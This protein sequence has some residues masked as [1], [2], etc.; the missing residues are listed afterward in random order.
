[1]STAIGLTACVASSQGYSAGR[2]HQSSHGEEPDDRRDHLG[3]GKGTMEASVV[4]PRHARFL[5]K[6]LSNARCR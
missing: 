6:N 5:A 2:N 3:M 1:V 4:E